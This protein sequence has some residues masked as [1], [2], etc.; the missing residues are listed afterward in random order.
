M[1]ESYMIKI[2]RALRGLQK[3]SFQ[4]RLDSWLKPIAFG[5]GFGRLL[6]V[7]SKN[8]SSFRNLSQNTTAWSMLS[9]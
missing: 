3:L 4:D 5:K 6:S 8:A 9:K 1:L 2:A 7:D